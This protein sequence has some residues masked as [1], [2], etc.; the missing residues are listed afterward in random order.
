MIV[1][2]VTT[3]AGALLLL[4]SIVMLTY[5]TWIVYVHNILREYDAGKTI[6]NRLIRD[7]SH[8]ISLFNRTVKAHVSMKP[9][10]T[11]MMYSK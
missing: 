11:G 4:C 10:R 1:G 9:G 5:S 2:I 3:G 6:V 8:E 7:I